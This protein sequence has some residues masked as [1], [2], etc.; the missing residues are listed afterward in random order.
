M[1][2]H[3]HLITFSDGGS[4]GNP[5]PSAY[6]YV[7]KT[8]TGDLLE[9]KGEY[10][11]VTT[12]NQAEYQ[13]ILAALR[14]CKEFGAEVVDMYM[15]SELAVKQLKGEYRVKNPGLAAIFL[16]IHNERI[17]FK[18]V[19]FHHVRREYNA[20]ADKEVNDALDRNG[21]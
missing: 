16:R 12:N 8:P 6:G 18:K 9:A 14:K 1:P 3:P 20:A 11:G 2:Q 10:I 15:D 13:G 21:K 19:S 4:R 5:G 7:V 17:H